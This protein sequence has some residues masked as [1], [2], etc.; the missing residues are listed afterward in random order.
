MTKYI[1]VGFARYLR[2]AN[3]ALVDYINN[4]IFKIFNGHTGHIKSLSYI[5]TETFTR[6]N[7]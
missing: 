2:S 7:R 6:P 5:N 1:A 3:I 4:K